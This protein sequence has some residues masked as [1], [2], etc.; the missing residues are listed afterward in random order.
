MKH[1]I[2]KLQSG[3]EVTF[4][5]HGNSMTPLIYSGDTVTVSPITPESKINVNDIVFC[6]VKG[7]IYLHLVKA[8]NGAGDKFLIGNNHGKINGW[9]SRNKIYGKLK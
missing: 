4:K 3:S 8:V 7:N 2:P 9:T 5:P 1:L 6:K